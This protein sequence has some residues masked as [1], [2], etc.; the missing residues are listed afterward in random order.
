VK[1]V[2]ISSESEQNKKQPSPRTRAVK[3]HHKALLVGEQTR[4][5]AD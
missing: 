5:I 3:Y 4:L 2:K 1:M